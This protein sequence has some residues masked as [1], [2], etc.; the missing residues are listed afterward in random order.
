MLAGVW[1]IFRKGL[2]DTLRDR[3]TLFFMLLMPTVAVPLLFWGINAVVRGVARE[4]AIK[5]VTIAASEETHDLYRRLVHEWFVETEI[6]VGLRTAKSPMVQALLRPD[7]VVVLERIPDEIFTDAEAFE[8]WTNALVGL[9]RQGVD[10]EVTEGK[11][12]LV[13]LPD[14]I[15][16]Q[17]IDFYRVIIKGLGLVEFVETESL[18]D[19]PASFDPETIPEDLRSLEHV[20]HIAAAIEGRSIQGFLEIPADV[21]KA[22]EQPGR[23]VEITFVHDSTIGQ[24]EEAWK[25]LDWVTQ[26]LNDKVVES[27][28]AAM[29]LGDAFLKPLAL[30]EDTDLASESEIIL[31]KAGGLLPY[32]IILFAFLGGM[33]PAIDLGAGEKERNTLETIILSPSTRTEIAVGKFGVIL[34]AALIAALLGVISITISVKYIILT[35]QLKEQFDFQIGPGTAALVALLAV[36]PA[37][38][39]SGIFLAISIYARSFKEAQNYIAP[40]QFAAILPA[41]AGLIPGLEMNW[42]IAL[43]PL[44]N[45]SLLSK[46][47]LKGDTDWGYYALTLASCLVLAGLCLAYCVRQFQR[48][49][50]LFRS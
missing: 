38:A 18:P 15:Q 26:L 42:R 8:A 33:Y 29:D 19:P 34:T 48:E 41:M 4:Q 16:D 2:T 37:A 46:D 24:S 12:P 3:K 45:V 10:V 20:G 49:E 44:V 32:V 23:T 27:R 14:E 50:V 21:L 11:G 36:P 28:L 43:I 35:G 13:K 31:A 1:I 30:R 7:A 39:F 47:F 40:L 17:L 22:R 5:V 9:V 6:G 25:R